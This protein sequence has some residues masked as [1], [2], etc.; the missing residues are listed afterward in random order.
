MMKVR[1]VADLN[2]NENSGSGKK[3]L[4]FRCIEKVQLI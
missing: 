2:Q 1:D 4:N 3:W